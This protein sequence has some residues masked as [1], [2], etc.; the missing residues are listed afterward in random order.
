[1][2]MLVSGRPEDLTD[3]KECKVIE[4]RT[5]ESKPC[6]KVFIFE[7]QTY[8][9]CTTV[10]GEN[11]KVSIYLLSIYLKGNFHNLHDIGT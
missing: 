7:D 10:K 1:M 2:F 5:G 3:K 11:G 8:Y 6:Q 4:K 9:G